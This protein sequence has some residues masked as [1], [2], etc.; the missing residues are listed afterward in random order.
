VQFDP[1]QLPQDSYQGRLNITMG[2]NTLRLLAVADVNRGLPGGPNPNFALV[3]DPNP[4]DFG[5]VQPVVGTVSETVTV[6]NASA[7]A[8][9]GGRYVFLGDVNLPAGFRV[10]PNPGFSTCIASGDGLA[11]TTRA[12]LSHGSCAF[13]VQ[14][15]PTQLLADTYLGRLNVTLG[16]NTLRVL[17]VADIARGVPGGPNSNFAL[18]ANPPYADFGRVRPILGTQSQTVTIEN[19]SAAAL[20]GGRYVFLGDVNLP[21][22]FNVDPSMST[23]IDTGSTLSGTTV[24]LLSHATCTFTVRFSPAQLPSGDYLGRLNITMG[25]NTLRYLSFA[26]VNRLIG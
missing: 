24:A 8:L 7:A 25:G 18:A 10:N 12:L 4:V 11:G 9:P 2:G 15:D 6:T 23:C 22:G 1:T 17:T 21:A 16:G 20:P 5:R 26:E 14:F 19:A 3:G 13:Q